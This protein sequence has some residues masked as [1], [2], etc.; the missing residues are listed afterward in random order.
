[1]FDGVLIDDAEV[2][3]DKLREWRDSNYHRPHGGLGGQT[4][5]ERL[6]Q[7]TTTQRNDHRRSHTGPAAPGTAPMRED[8]SHT[9]LG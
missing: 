1:M 3:N 7:K 8:H 9:G 6:R 4:R 5:Y 2:F